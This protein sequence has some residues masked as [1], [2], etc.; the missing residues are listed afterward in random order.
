MYNL[1]YVME[2]YDVQYVIYNIYNLAIN[3][4]QI[5]DDR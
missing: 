3:K 5:A 2:K 4:Q 1:N